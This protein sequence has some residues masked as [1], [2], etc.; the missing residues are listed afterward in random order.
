MSTDNNTL[1]IQLLDKPWQI[2][3]PE[4]K[5]PELQKCA[6]FLDNKMREITHGTKGMISERVVVMAAIN[7]IYDMLQQLNQKDLYIDSLSSRV[8]ELQNKIGKNLPLN[9]EMEV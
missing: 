9:Q 8:R 4:D 1:T 5:K 7:V 3:C 6:R 2:R